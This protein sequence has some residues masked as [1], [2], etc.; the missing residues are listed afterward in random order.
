MTLITEYPDGT[1]YGAAFVVGHTA[2]MEILLSAYGA[3]QEIV[4]GS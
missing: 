2:Q 3:R 1:I 4:A